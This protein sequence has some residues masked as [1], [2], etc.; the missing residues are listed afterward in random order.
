M[1]EVI[2]KKGKKYQNPVANKHED[3]QVTGFG[4]TVFM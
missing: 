1:I 2:S 4:S 3:K